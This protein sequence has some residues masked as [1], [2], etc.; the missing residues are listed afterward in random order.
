MCGLTWEEVKATHKQ[1]NIPDHSISNP[2]VVSRSSATSPRPRSPRGAPRLPD[3][4]P[5]TDPC[6][7]EAV[8]SAAK[9]QRTWGGGRGK[10]TSGLPRGHKTAYSEDRK[11]IRPPADR[12][13]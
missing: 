6:S 2:G 13:R 1:L 3:T 10:N 5:L 4:T 9:M 7:I 11:V 8:H 12:H